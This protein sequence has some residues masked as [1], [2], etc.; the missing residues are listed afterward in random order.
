MVHDVTVKAVRRLCAPTQCMKY[1]LTSSTA[2]VASSAV[3]RRLRGGYPP[4]AMLPPPLGRANTS[5]PAHRSRTAP[6]PRF[7]GASARIATYLVRARCCTELSAM[8]CGGDKTVTQ[9]KSSLADQSRTTV[10]RV[11]QQGARCEPA[12]GLTEFRSPCQ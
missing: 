12:A 2:S 9:S 4:T 6:K 8:S 5:R 11:H 3:A 7:T 10:L 1:E